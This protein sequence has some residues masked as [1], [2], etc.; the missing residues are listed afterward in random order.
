MSQYAKTSLIVEYR[1]TAVDLM[2]EIQ[3]LVDAG[4]MPDMDMDKSLCEEMVIGLIKDVA[5]GGLCGATGMSNNYYLAGIIEA[6]VKAYLANTNLT[7]EYIAT[8]PEH[9]R[10]YFTDNG[11]RTA[12]LN[13][14]AREGR[15][16][17]HRLLTKHPW[18]VKQY[19]LDCLEGIWPGYYA[20]M[21]QY[22]ST[23]NEMV[24]GRDDA[25]IANLERRMDSND[26]MLGFVDNIQNLIEDIGPLYRLRELVQV[27]IQGNV[28]DVWNVSVKRGGICLLDYE[29]D[30]RI[31][32]WTRQQN[33]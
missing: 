31:L 1:Q 3:N 18:P 15:N 28:F 13:T 20:N 16:G 29:G 33:Q 23:I 26:K 14:Y 32:E 11:N 7:R 10:V 22:L 30:H 24:P 9:A 5:E 2:D 12:I 21:T 8:M 6:K 4:V 25:A 27:R 19:I 17:L